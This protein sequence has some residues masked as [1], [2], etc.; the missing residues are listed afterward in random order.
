MSGGFY[1]GNYFFRCVVSANCFRYSEVLTNYFRY[2][3]VV[4]SIYFQRIIVIVIVIV[5]VIEQR[6]FSSKHAYTGYCSS[7][8]AV[9]QKKINKLQN[10][11]AAG[12]LHLLIRVLKTS[13]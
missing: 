5:I 13:S 12:A 9:E 4:S 10:Q 7:V 3:V 8:A 1:L 11:F 6:D 2:L